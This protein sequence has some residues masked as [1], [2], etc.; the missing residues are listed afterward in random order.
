MF[1]TSKME[2]ATSK[3]IFTHHI[4]QKCPKSLHTFYKI[5]LEDP[6]SISVHPKHIDLDYGSILGL[7]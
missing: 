3:N 4:Y 6:A 7:K 1:Q 2:I 5:F